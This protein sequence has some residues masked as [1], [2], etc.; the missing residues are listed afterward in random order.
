MPSVTIP[1]DLQDEFNVISTDLTTY[2]E[3]WMGA[4]LVGEMDVDDDATWEEYLMGLN[5]IGLE[6]YVEIYNE[7]YQVSPLQWGA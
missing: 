3:E 1:R 2:Y 6:R 5:D 7:A 4:F